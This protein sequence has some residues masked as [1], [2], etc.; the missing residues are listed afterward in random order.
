MLH[1]LPVAT[2]PG[3]TRWTV[4]CSL[5]LCGSL[6][7]S[8]ALSGED[9][10][11]GL[12]APPPA[13]SQRRV[14]MSPLVCSR[15]VSAVSPSVPRP[16]TPWT[17]CLCGI[18]PVLSLYLTSCSPPANSVSQGGCHCGLHVDR[19]LRLR[20]PLVDALTDHP[21]VADKEAG[22]RAGGARS[23]SWRPKG[24][25]SHPPPGRWAWNYKLE[26][27][28]RPAL[29]HGH[30]RPGP[31]AVAGL[32]SSQQ[33]ALAVPGSE[34]PRRAPGAL[35]ALV[36]RGPGLGALAGGRSGLHRV[37][38]FAPFLCALGPLAEFPAFPV[39]LNFF[40]YR[41]PAL[42]RPVC[43][44]VTVCGGLDFSL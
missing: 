40:L 16:A 34:R 26:V 6:R 43:H 14:A 28:F 20:A 27:A 36:P 33:T 23:G 17:A 38:C 1:A 44:L 15:G 10:R 42:F 24:V 32:P 37:P 31:C 18:L 13:P 39:L 4:S 25:S 41:F 22:G 7:S 12:P 29:L 11:A 30:Q 9:H 8:P 2:E 5:C 35:P 3:L 21:C 19:V